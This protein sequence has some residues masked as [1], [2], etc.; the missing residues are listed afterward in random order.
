MTAKEAEIFLS[1]FTK[2]VTAGVIMTLQV[3][4]ALGVPKETRERIKDAFRRAFKEE[5]E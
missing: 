4:A 5:P 3:A 2:G 1:A